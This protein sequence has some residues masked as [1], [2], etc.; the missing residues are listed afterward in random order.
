[1][2]QISVPFF[3]F[4]SCALLFVHLEMQVQKMRKMKLPLFCPIVPLLTPLA[5]L[6]FPVSSF[7]LFSSSL[8]PLLDLKPFVGFFFRCSPFLHGFCC[9]W[10]TFSEFLFLLF[11]Y[12]FSFLC[13]S[14]FL[15]PFFFLSLNPPLFF[16]P[17]LR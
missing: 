8:D 7:S 15:S 3:I 12:F 14:V 6:V 5:P 4:L 11:P 1:M 9:G 13:V 2:T 10:V 16:S 17:F